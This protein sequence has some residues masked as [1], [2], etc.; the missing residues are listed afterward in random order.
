MSAIH[1]SEALVKVPL[2]LAHT[3]CTWIGKTPPLPP[4]PSDEREQFPNPDTLS[5]TIPFQRWFM[6]ASKCFLCAVPLAEVMVLIAQ[7]FPLTPTTDRLL[8]F[9][10]RPASGG[11]LRLTPLS[12]F[13]CTLG[14]TGG[15]IRFWCYRTLGRFFTW[16]V[17]VQREHKLV[18]DGPY[19]IVRHPGY[20][21]AVLMN[22]GNILLLLSE[23]S[24]VVEAGWLQDGW[25]KAVVYG[26]IGYSA[27]ISYSL[28]RRVPREDAMLRKEFGLQWREWTKRT[29]YCLIPFVY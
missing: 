19:V 3:V 26:V 18:T 6:I 24:Y 29:P 16:Q 12:A 17:S 23:G 9:L 10:F 5:L 22:A 13:A 25:G 15:L 14:I 1:T 8:T 11:S 20:T 28:I 4:P 27:Y 2:L 7:H 21:G